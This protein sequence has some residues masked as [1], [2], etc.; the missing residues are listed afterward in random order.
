M[1]SACVLHTCVLG[2]MMWIDELKW[3]GSEAWHAA[4]KRAVE[5][6]GAHEAYVRSAGNLVL[7]TVL[8]AGHSVSTLQS[9][10]LY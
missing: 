9:P 7:Y 3:K 6:N 8:R 4:N 2:T 1:K 5:L 10:F